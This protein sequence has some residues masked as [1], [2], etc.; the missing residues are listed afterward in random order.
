MHHEGRSVCDVE[1]SHRR[2]IEGKDLV[3]QL[4]TGFHLSKIPPSLSTTAVETNLPIDE[5][6]GDPLEPLQKHLEIFKQG[7][8]QK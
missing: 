4:P 6:A 2:Q 1:I 3:L 8:L 7:S 5:P